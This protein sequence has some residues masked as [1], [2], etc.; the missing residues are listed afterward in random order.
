MSQYFHECCLNWYKV[1]KQVNF[2]L[3]MWMQHSIL[4]F[5]WIIYCLLHSLLASIWMKKRMQ[6]RMKT[7]FRYYRFDHHSCVPVFHSFIFAFPGRMGYS[8]DWNFDNCCRCGNYAYD[9]QE[10]LH[11]IKWCPLAYAGICSIKT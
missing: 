3:L 8:I 10:I 11:A 1:G 7:F 2:I 9:D 4:A 5:A 6:S